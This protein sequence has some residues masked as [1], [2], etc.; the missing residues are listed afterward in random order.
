MPASFILPRHSES[1][2]SFRETEGGVHDL[3]PVLTA[4]REERR[5]CLTSEDA[6]VEGTL[7]LPVVPAMAWQYV[8]DPIERQR[9]ACRQFGKDADEMTANA[10]GR[11]GAGAK[12]HCG[13]GPGPIWGFREFI[14]WRPFDYVTSL[15][16]TPVAGAFLRPRPATETIEFHPLGEDGTRVIWRFRMTKRSC[17]S[18]LALRAFRPFW[19]AFGRRAGAA[20][21]SIAEVDAAVE[22]TG[23]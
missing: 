17:L 5:L 3:G 6:D 12:T 16:T 7:D 14:D 22:S 1:Y 13:H 21:V 10:Q 18:L 8:L 20:L 2:E 15:T 9:W 19:L 23:C 11:R 4:M